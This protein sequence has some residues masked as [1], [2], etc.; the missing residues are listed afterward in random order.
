[1]S[2]YPLLIDSCPGYLGTTE[3][4]LI[5]FPMGAGS[6]GS[7][8]CKQL[9]TVTRQQPLVMGPP[10]VANG[11]RD[12]VRDATSGA[13]VVAD[14]TELDDAL[15]ELDPS[16]EVLVVDPRCFPADGFEPQALLSRRDAD[17]RW[18][19]HLVAFGEG[20]KGG[21]K[22]YAV[23]DGEGRVRMV[24]RYYDEVTWPF[25]AGVAASLMP[26][27]VLRG[28][29]LLATDLAELRARLAAQ[30]VP[31]RD[32]PL[33]GT[34]FDLGDEAGLLALSERFVLKATAAR[35]R[36]GPL[37]VGNGQSVHPTSRLVGPVVV[38]PGVVIG[39]NATVL[40]P[41]LLG[42][43]ARIGPGAIVAQSVVGPACVV[44]AGER[45]RHRAVLPDGTGPAPASR[46]PRR[47]YLT[48]HLSPEDSQ[49]GAPSPR[50]RYM[51]V[52]RVLES[53]AAAAGLVLLLPLMLLLAALVAL[54]SR[55]PI[56]YGHDR[57]GWRGRRFR[58]LKF[59]TMYVGAQERERELRAH[60]LVDGPQFKM[61]RDPRTTTV[62]RFLR[63]TS[64]DELPQL[65]NVV[66][67]EM[68][69]V[70]PRPSP[71]REN[72]LCVDWRTGRLSVR[73]G[74]T[75]LWQVCRHDRSEG[76]FHQWI[77]YDLLYVRHMSLAVDLRI[78]AATILTLGGR[79]SAPVDRVLGRAARLG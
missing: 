26:A 29:E 42:A 73:P 67:G 55:G 40:G 23:L 14:L 25:I 31:S 39:E 37:M 79:R 10:G 13:R 56:L 3:Q 75:G 20:R 30:G 41:A 63:A 70:G 59:R 74:I 65:I 50:T 27:S 9:E 60:S 38:H 43:G 51:R 15:A 47:L 68:A 12:H 19:S 69:L 58:C 62:G 34:A 35:S 48:T 49:H 21:T 18:V 57:E 52:K 22:E 28:E 11:Y 71:F 46:P 77:E 44:P 6:L 33:A 76:D 24:R 54:D 66:R 32:L 17:P 72:Q 4:T 61:E 1:L 2:V 53:A 16:D 45:V 36:S 8:L 64:L 5:L 7:H 78:L